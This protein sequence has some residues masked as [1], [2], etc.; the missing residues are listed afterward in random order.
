MSNDKLKPVSALQRKFLS[1][2]G[3]TASDHQEQVKSL[4]NKQ[5]FRA[6]ATSKAP[7]LRQI[8][9]AVERRLT[10][11]EPSSE[12][13]ARLAAKAAQQEADVIQ[14]ARNVE[15][16]PDAYVLFIRHSRCLSCGNTSRCLDLPNLFLRHHAKQPL[17][18]D[19]HRHLYLPTK[20]FAHPALPRI[21]ESRFAT[22]PVCEN[23][24]ERKSKCVSSISSASIASL[25]DNPKDTSTKSEASSGFLSDS[26]LSIMRL[27]DEGGLI[28]QEESGID[29]S[30]SSKSLSAPV[31]PTPSPI[32]SAR[33]VA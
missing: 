26:T 3:E 15:W 30:E 28:L 12:I 9:N 25:P 29:C 27:E 33:E 18:D 22:L 14:R 7:S 24:F 31:L 6:S 20:V 23:C 32:D 11:S 10:Y 13:A 8:N 5:L 16:I 21:M 1:L 4:L 17:A 2:L 19:S